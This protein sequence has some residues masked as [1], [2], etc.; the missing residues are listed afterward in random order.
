MLLHTAHH[1]TG[2]M[3]LHTWLFD[4]TDTNI[5]NTYNQ[6]IKRPNY[7]YIDALQTYKLQFHQQSRSQ[8]KPT[9][10]KLTPLTNTTQLTKTTLTRNHGFFY[11]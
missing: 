8:D 9:A 1:G 5:P 7:I 4:Y 10:T 3:S 11:V 2:T 6:S